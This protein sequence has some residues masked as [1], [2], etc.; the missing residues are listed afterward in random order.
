MGGSFARTGLPLPVSTTAYNANNQLTTWGTANLFYDLNGNMTSDGTHSYTW[1]ARNHLS[2]IDSGNAATFVYDPLGRRAQKVVAGTSTSFLYDG[3]N[4]VQEVIGGSNTANSL[5]GGVD[6]VFQRTDSAGAR[7]FLTDALG[8]TLALTD[9]TA[10]LQ[11]QYTFDPFGNTSLAG[12]ST[13]NSFAYTGRE[14]DAMGIYFYRARYYNP[15]LQ[16]FVSEDP[17][18]FRGGLNFYPYVFNS[19]PNGTDPFGRA[20]VNLGGSLNISFGSL[21]FQYDG[22]VVIDTNGNFGVYNTA[23][24]GA[25]VNTGVSGSFGLSGGASSGKNICSFGGPFVE[26]GGNA[27]L[28]PA[29]GASGYAGIE[30]DGTP[31][32]GGSVNVGAGAG[33]E[34]YVD[35]TSTVV[36]PLFG[37]KTV[38]P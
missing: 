15:G 30:S 37:R 4:A 9:S 31:I 17:I 3:A 14:L 10:A 33:A 23:G 24:L 8:S 25:A 29:G 5:M 13:T 36:T 11:T 20:T 27:G 26:L 18:R 2:K 35:A 6:E 16:R 19:P 7:S 1:D 32:V 21:H 22:G 12:A 38:C 34:A 28:G